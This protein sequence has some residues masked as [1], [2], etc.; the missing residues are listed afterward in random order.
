M[1]INI[2]DLKKAIKWVEEH[3]KEE[4]INVYIV[5]GFSGSNILSLDCKDKYTKEVEIEIYEAGTLLPKI[6]KTEIL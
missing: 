1:R 3:T 5:S 4:I 6:K 2:S